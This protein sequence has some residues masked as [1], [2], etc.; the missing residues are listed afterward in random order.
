ML[1]REN[2]FHLIQ[3]KRPHPLVTL[4][5][6]LLIVI[7]VALILLNKPFPT[8]LA[9]N[10]RRLGSAKC[11]PCRG[12]L[13]AGRRLHALINN[14]C[15]GRSAFVISHINQ[16]RVRRCASP[17]SRVDSDGASITPTAFSASASAADIDRAKPLKLSTGKPQ[18]KAQGIVMPATMR[19]DHVGETCMFL[20]LC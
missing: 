3:L 12:H 20:L 6:L 8:Q 1:P 10:L 18:Q 4:L 17:A 13:F 15:D 11:G 2:T 19:L 5:I 7:G 16:I 9:S 14:K